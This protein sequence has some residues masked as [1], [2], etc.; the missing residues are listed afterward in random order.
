[1]V[2]ALTLPSVYD[3]ASPAV[4][5]DTKEVPGMGWK[6]NPLFGHA[7]GTVRAPDGTPLAGA[8]VQLLDDAT[9]FLV[10]SAVADGSGWFAFVD[11]PANTYRLTTDASLVPGGLVGRATVVAGTVATFS[12]TGAAAPSATPTPTPAPS[13]SPS[14]LPPT[15][16]Q[17]T[18]GPG[19]AA[20][21]RVASGVAG[22]HASWDG[23]SGYP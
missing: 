13:A 7:K 21:E 12:P 3:P 5:A 19:I 20:P 6:I 8:R 1:L 2:K 23:Q 17:S 16:C 10:R 9:G 11:L 14:P 15:S 22:F 18:V 4:F